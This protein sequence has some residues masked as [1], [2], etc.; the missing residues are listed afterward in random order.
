MLYLLLVLN[1]FIMA[2]ALFLTRD[3]LSP[4]VLLCAIFSFCTVCAIMGNFDWQ[5]NISGAV[6]AVV[7]CGLLCILCGELV[8]R[9]LG[10]N[11]NTDLKDIGKKQL[12]KQ[13]VVLQKEELN[14]KDDGVISYSKWVMVVLSL[15]SVACVLIY[16]INVIQLA[17][18]S[19]YVFGS[20]SLLQYA[21]VSL[22]N[23]GKLNT[24]VSVL[25]FLARGIGFV[26]LAIFIRNVLASPK[27]FGGIVKNLWCVT[28]IIMLIFLT[29]LSTG[30]TGFILLAV[31]IFFL[32]FERI[33]A[34]KKINL[35]VVGVGGVVCVVAFFVLFLLLGKARG[36]LEAY[37]PLSLIWIYAGSSLVALDNWLIAGVRN[38]AIFGGESFIGIHSLIARF[39]PNYTAPSYFYEFVTFPNGIQ[40]NIYTGFR[41][42]INDF[43]YVGCMLVCVIFGVVFGF[44]YARIIY[45]KSDKN[46][47]LYKL[48]YA[49]TLYLLLI[50]FASPELTIFWLSV[51]QI[52]D[53]L[54]IIL[55]YYAIARFDFKKWRLR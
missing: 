46:I 23:G 33:R 20:G 25:G 44:A 12:L 4:S 31:V 29:F 8:G 3:V 34:V 9:F 37:N 5:A 21:R 22:L 52:F 54:F 26:C 41:A 16:F 39:F 38:T 47:T 51:T 24:I 35:L 10:R 15:I 28:P 50:S 43:G 45:K 1:V 11:K 17:I 19:G 36:Q 42:W 7:A 30:R 48:L 49:Y 27:F 53:F 55:V 18:I 32:V 13:G 40:T 6:V 2:V 14:S